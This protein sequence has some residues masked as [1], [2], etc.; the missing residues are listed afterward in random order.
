[1]PVGTEAAVA[2]DV[3]DGDAGSGAV[4]VAGVAGAAVAGAETLGRAEATDCST[5]AVQPINAISDIAVTT[6]AI[7]ERGWG[8]MTGLR[9][10]RSA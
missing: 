2:V 1:H 5:S 4:G 10:R 9:M 8:R 3:G 7:D 6:P